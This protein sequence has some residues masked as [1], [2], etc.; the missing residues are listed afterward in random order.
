MRK[1]LGFLFLLIV[2]LFSSC[3]NELPYNYQAIEL[4]K[5]PD[6]IAYSGN[7]Q[8]GTSSRSAN[9]NGNLWYQNWDRPTNVTEDEIAKVLA[10]VAEPRVGATNTIHIDWENYWV[11]QVYTGETV[12]EDGYKNSI[13]TGSSH[14]NHLLAYN[15]NVEVWWP[16]H[17]YGGYEHINNFNNGSNNTIYVDDV[18]G[19]QFIG[20]TLMTDMNA[21]G[22]T[23]QFGYNNSTDSKD[24]FEYIIVEVDGSYY[25]CFDFYATHPEGQDANKNMDVERDWVFNDWIVKIS[26]AYHK[27]E[28]P[29]EPEV[30][31]PEIPVIDN[32]VE[33]NLS[34]NDELDN[35]DYTSSHLSIH[36]RAATDV[37]VFIPVP[38]EY[39]C[40]ADD[41]AIV[42]KHEPNHMIHGGP[43]VTEYKLKDSDLVVTLTVAFEP[44]GI[45]ITTNGITQ[46]VIDWCQEKCQDGITFE[47]WN[48]F[49]DNITRE[50]LKKYLDKSTIRFLDGTPEYKNTINN[51]KDCT[52][53]ELN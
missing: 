43:F 22:I 32:E 51:E 28:T 50:L 46:E 49:N 35:G 39:Y 13:G 19:E 17:T 7:Y 12:Y 27:G 42:M 29:K 4:V 9:V 40:Q 52:V 24:H 31:N 53:S 10:V 37:E 6:V 38:M 15:K 26:P 11:Q 21:E 5:R 20:T 14:M 1:L 48:Y 34:I 16:E 2:G 23:N 47:V 41:M 30:S 25:V 3:T 8:F 33:V 18:T 36:V 44:E 45:R